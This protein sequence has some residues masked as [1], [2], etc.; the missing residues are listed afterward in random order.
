MNQWLGFSLTLQSLTIENNYGVAV[1]F[2]QIFQYAKNHALSLIQ[3]HYSVFI[4]FAFKRIIAVD[5]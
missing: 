5:L 2:H 1:Q 4:R 3:A